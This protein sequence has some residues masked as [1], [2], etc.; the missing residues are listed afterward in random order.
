MC[1]PV[2]TVRKASRQNSREE[3]TQSIRQYIPA[4]GIPAGD[5]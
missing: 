2:P 1:M 5:K 4:A 3:T